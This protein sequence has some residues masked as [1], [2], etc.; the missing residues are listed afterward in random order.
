M[1]RINFQKNEKASEADLANS[2]V[3]R[4]LLEEEAG[5]GPASGVAAMSEYQEDR[6]YAGVAAPSENR[7]LKTISCM[8]DHTGLSSFL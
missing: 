1:R 4:A 6:N 2:A 5:K 3:R 8:L 7:V